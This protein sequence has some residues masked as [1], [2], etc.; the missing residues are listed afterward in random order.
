MSP[1]PA[2]LRI[3]IFT[4]FPEPVDSMASVSVIGRARAAGLLDVRVHDLRSAAADR[5]RSVDDAPFGGGAG[6][7]MAP[8]PLFAAVEAVDPPRPLLCLSPAGRLFDQAWA[9]HLAATGG[10]SMLCGRYEGIDER[11]SEHLPTVSCRWEMW[12]W[13]AARQPPCWFWRRWAGACP[14]CSAMRRRWWRNPSGTGLLEYPQYT[15]PARFRCWDVPEVLLSGDHGRVARWRRAQALARTV[16][17][18]PDLIAARG[19]L[20]ASEI[21]L[22]QISIRKMLEIGEMP[23]VIH[24]SNCDRSFPESYLPTIS[25]LDWRVSD[26]EIRIFLTRCSGVN[27][28]AATQDVYERV[29]C[30]LAPQNPEPIEARNLR[31]R[32]IVTRH[33][34]QSWCQPNHAVDQVEFLNQ[35]QEAIEDTGVQV[36]IVLLREIQR[37]I[38]LSHDLLAPTR[39][40]DWAL[41]LRLLP[42]I[43]YHHE[44]IDAMRI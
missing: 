7:V 35:L 27:R 30:L 10:F 3:D 43:A 18:R 29:A 42:W 24:F 23:W 44:L 39:A 16:E 14:A 11:V 15:R 20:S 1:I 26:G 36:P 17:R 8:R 28:C 21:Q 6:M 34:W 22:P 25:R 13:P 19:G 38:G 37:Y 40:L 32:D 9:V 2:R 31:P 5:H 33:E 4:I 41:T 12:C